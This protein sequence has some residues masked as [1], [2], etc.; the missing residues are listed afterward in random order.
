MRTFSPLP[1]GAD[2]VEALRAWAAS[3]GATAARRARIVLL[4][5]EGHGPSAVAAIV[6]CS[7]TTVLT[8]R[9]R[10]RSDGIAGLA[11]APRAGRPVTV[12]PVSVIERTLFA[13]PSRARTRRWSSRLLAEELGI[14][15]VAVA[16]IWRTWGICPLDDG[17]VRLGS[18]PPLDDEL[19]AFAAV[20]VDAQVAVLAVVVGDRSPQ[21]RLP[22]RARPRLGGRFGRVDVG[23]AGDPDGLTGLL[24]RLV[25]DDRLRLLTA[26]AAAPARRWAQHRGTPV[27]A[28]ADCA[29]WARFVRVSAVLAGATACGAA[30]VAG[31][32]E[33][34]LA[35]EPGRALQWV[36]TPAK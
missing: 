22:M 20:H 3:A 1:V 33:A 29:D 19:A 15:N 6:G 5:G 27:H 10:Y 31:L 9:E 26:G 28:A 11:D 30:S 34:V 7:P 8:W 18:E 13:P 21:E 4:S 23:P 2:E 35:H 36:H 24:D 14:S 12:D 25:P 32:R 17:H 16:K